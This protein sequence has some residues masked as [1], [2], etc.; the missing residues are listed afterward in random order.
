MSSAS[1]ED[2][3]IGGIIERADVYDFTSSS[4][5]DTIDGTKESGEQEER[6][7]PVRFS[8]R[9]STVATASDQGKGLLSISRDH[10]ERRRGSVSA[11]SESR[12]KERDVTSKLKSVKSVMALAS[13][14]EAIPV[15]G[16]RA[17]S[18]R[19]SMML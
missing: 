13:D 6:A 15:G 8:R 9:H 7:K 3:I 16:E 1:Q 19:R 4:P 18:R 11:S 17:T 2:R 5:G 10:L 14:L 12:R